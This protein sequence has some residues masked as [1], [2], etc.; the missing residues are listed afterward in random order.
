MKAVVLVVMFFLIMFTASVLA[1][2]FEPNKIILGDPWD[3]PFDMSGALVF[4]SN[5][6]TLTAHD[7]VAWCNGGGLYQ[8]GQGPRQYGFKNIPSGYCN[9]IELEYITP[10]EHT[11]YLFFIWTNTN[12]FYLM[13][14]FGRQ[15]GYIEMNGDNIDGSHVYHPSDYDQKVYALND[16]VTPNKA[17]ERWSIYGAD[18]DYA[19]M[20]LSTTGVH[21]EYHNI[22]SAQV[23][24]VDGQ[25]RFWLASTVDSGGYT[26]FRLFGCWDVASCWNDTY[27]CWDILQGFRCTR[28]ICGLNASSCGLYASMPT[29]FPYGYRVRDID[30]AHPVDGD[31]V[32]LSLSGKNTT[33]SENVHA[34]FK[35]GQETVGGSGQCTSDKECVEL[36]M[37]GTISAP[38]GWTCG[39]L[40]CNSSNLCTREYHVTQLNETNDRGEFTNVSYLPYGLNNDNALGTGKG[41]GSSVYGVVNDGLY[42]NTDYDRQIAEL[43]DAVHMDIFPRFRIPYGSYY[44]SPVINMGLPPDFLYYETDP[45]GEGGS[46][47]VTMRSSPDADEWTDWC[48]VAGVPEDKYVQVKVEFGYEKEYPVNVEWA[49]LDKVTIY[50]FQRPKGSRGFA[51]LTVCPTVAGS[52][53]T[54]F[55][56]VIREEVFR[57]FE[58]VMDIVDY[59]YEPSLNC[60]TFRLE[61][62]LYEVSVFKPY[63]GAVRPYGEFKK[64]VVLVE[65]TTITPNMKI[66]TSACDIDIQLLD[67]DYGFVISE[68]GNAYVYVE[69]Y[70]FVQTSDNLVHTLG[71]VVGEDYWWFATAPHYHNKTFE[72]ERCLRTFEHVKMKRSEVLANISVIDE[73]GTAVGGANLKITDVNGTVIIDSIMGTS[74]AVYLSVGS[75]LFEI[76]KATYLTVSESH[77]LEADTDIVVQL[78]VAVT[79]YML[80]LVQN[81]NATIS[82]VFYS[83]EAKFNPYVLMLIAFVVSI[84]IGVGGALSAPEGRGLELGMGSALLVLIFFGIIGWLSELFLIVF[85]IIAGLL[86]AKVML[87]VMFGK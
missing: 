26:L 29:A 45:S 65:D 87:S 84:A 6:E 74:Y 78:R 22:D 67:E 55:S 39:Q 7:A 42:H 68:P 52:P 79:G 41:G 46:I 15:W 11:D 27:W 69:G 86:L 34:Y 35:L 28:E 57:D 53:T 3:E 23:M 17:V 60:K 13:D 85:I 77:L 50:Y 16:N 9:Q 71:L 59:G 44:I 48:S 20:D 32:L 81:I 63:T 76:S 18:Y 19:I 58:T 4:Y 12:K 54:T 10:D 14:I 66:Y 30:V 70:P 49:T 83:A 1:V 72:T 21:P 31:Y 64:D 61:K 75:Y 2:D 47:N 73:N 43:T 62:G 8:W 51:N 80:T 56:V 37:N 40:G 24:V 5:N 82:G 38:T 36:C 33:G 25:D